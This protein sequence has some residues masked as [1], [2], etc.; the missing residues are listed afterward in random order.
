M[1]LT[2]LNARKEALASANPKGDGSKCLNELG[3][4]DGHRQELVE[5][6][7]EAVVHEVGQ[8]DPAWSKRHVEVI[9]R[10]Q[11][12]VA[13]AGRSECVVWR[14]AQFCVSTSPLNR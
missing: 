1:R 8:F 6:G 10:D 13:C 14:R 11:A 2:D 3:L 5:H 4:G 12:W 7:R 9:G